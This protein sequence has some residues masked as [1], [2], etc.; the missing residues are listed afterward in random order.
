MAFLSSTLLFGMK[1]EVN[2]KIPPTSKRVVQ[3]KKKNIEA[4]ENITIILTS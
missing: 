4:N 3:K 1:Y 2:A